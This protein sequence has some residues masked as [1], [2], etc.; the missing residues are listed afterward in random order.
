MASQIKLRCTARGCTD[1]SEMSHY[2]NDDL[3]QFCLLNIPLGS[4]TFKR[5]KMIYVHFVG[6]KCP[7]VKRGKWNAELPKV[8]N[9]FGATHAGLE[10]NTKELISFEKI[11]EKLQKVFVSDDG[12]FSIAALK[13]EYNKRLKEEAHL[14]APGSP[15]VGIP[16]GDPFADPDICS[17]PRRNRKLAK[18]L[19]LEAPAVLKALQEDFGP[20]NWSIFEPDDKAL[21]LIDAGSNGVDELCEELIK[22]KDKV[23]FGVFRMAFGTGRFR[24]TKRIFYHWIGEACPAVAKGKWNLLSSNMM[25]SLSPFNVD[26]R[27]QGSEEANL[28]FILAKLQD[29]FVSDNIKMPG[30]DA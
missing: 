26:M 28:A 21:K 3:V 19:G 7:A 16:D 1:I 29:V 5:N 13:E 18:E 2:L 30:E 14:A 22:R 11:L 15:R 9:V 12:S 17:S 20:F 4:G 24:R 25:K 10:V 27:I 23:L 6:Q 8:L